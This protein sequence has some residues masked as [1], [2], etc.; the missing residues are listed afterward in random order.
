[1]R[2][3]VV[4]KKWKSY[5]GVLESVFNVKI[6]KEVDKNE[7]PYKIDESEQIPYFPVYETHFFTLKICLKT[8]LRLIQRRLPPLPVQVHSESATV[9]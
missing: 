6:N 9:G 8:T 5:K 1:M 3:T 2:Q 4:R 7:Y